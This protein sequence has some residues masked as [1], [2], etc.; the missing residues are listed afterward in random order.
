M[1][2]G[3]KDPASLSRPP[4]PGRCCL[5]RRVG[6]PRMWSHLPTFPHHVSWGSQCLGRGPQLGGMPFPW[7][8]SPA[9]IPGTRVR[10][11]GEGDS[12]AISLACFSD[13]PW[14]STVPLM[15]RGLLLDRGTS[16]DR[17]SPRR[18][19]TRDQSSLGNGPL[20]RARGGVGWA[21]REFAGKAPP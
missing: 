21:P 14:F 17:S 6:Q 8:P 4:E 3:G 12:P 20:C 2:P 1:P 11:A 19:P 9:S 18:G 10:A 16:W 5:D 15:G 7:A 13:S